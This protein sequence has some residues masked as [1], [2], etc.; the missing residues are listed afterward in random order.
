MPDAT[1][2]HFVCG[3]DL[4]QRVDRTALVCLQ[5]SRVPVPEAAGP[6]GLRLKYR[7]E[8]RGLKRWP[9]GTSY[10]D[11][12][13][14]V[15]D[16]VRKPPLAGCTL[17][18]DVTGVGLAVL[19]IIRAARPKAVIRPVLIT[20]GHE[21]TPDGAGYHV[22]KLELAGVVAALLDSGRLAIPRTV[23]PDAETLGKELLAFRV[24]V[25]AAGNEKMEADWRSRQ[26]DDM[27]LALSIAAW[28]GE[29]ATRQPW[30]RVD[31]V[32]YGLGADAPAS[33]RRTVLP[34]G[35]VIEETP[36]GTQTTYSGKPAK[37]GLDV[38]S[39]PSSKW[40]T[41]RAGRSSA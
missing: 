38:K 32:T 31:G 20:A 41:T 12:A 35:T 19:E 5:R 15:A 2:A 14:A 22:P 11:I 7:Y 39:S 9:L 8:A 27:V 23:G 26:H 13:L 28:L 25:T 29:A 33:P 16:L 1:Q 36:G 37:S 24:K 21:V 30:I 10:C 40:A 6:A 34:D 3:L 17:G 4:G 18:V